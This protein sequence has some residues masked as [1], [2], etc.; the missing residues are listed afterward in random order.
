MPAKIPRTWPGSSGDAARMF[1]ADL[2]R[3]GGADWDRTVSYP[4]PAIRRAVTAVASHLHGA[5]GP[6]SPARRPSA[7]PRPDGPGATGAGGSL[8]E[9]GP[10]GSASA[11]QAPPASR[12]RP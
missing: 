2:A 3:L 7:D 4:L 1:A 9:V 8:A 5:R 6:P 11:V 12:R 10:A